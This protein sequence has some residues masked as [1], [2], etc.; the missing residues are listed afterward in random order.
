MAV[1]GICIR[2]GQVN[3]NQIR[4]L[5]AGY[6]K[7]T[8]IEP[9]EKNALQSMLEYAA[10]ATSYWRFWQYHINNPTP[11]RADWH[12]KMARFSEVVRAIPKDEFIDKV[13]E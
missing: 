12:W 5:L 13:F 7:I 2:N 6:S 11:G 8:T 4:P 1:L 3:F 9:E 10:I